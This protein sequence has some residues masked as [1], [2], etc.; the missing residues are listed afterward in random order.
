LQASLCGHLDVVQLLLDNGALC[1]RDTFQGERCLH[2]ALNDKIKKLL[3]DHDYSKSTNP[4]Q[5]YAAH[6]TS[7]LSRERPDTFDLQL[8]CGNA[9]LQAHK[10]ILA[11]RSPHFAS[12]LNQAPEMAT[13]K[14][15]N[16]VPVESIYAILRFMYLSEL[17]ND[18][19]TDEEEEDILR[20]IEKFSRHIDI[21]RLF[22]FAL[23]RSDRRLT[24]QR[25]TD[26][27][28]RGRDEIFAWF[29]DN[30]L[31][32]KLTV[33]SSKVADI[34]WNRHNSVFADVL[35]RA[36]DYDDDDN[37]SESNPSDLE[38]AS[39]PQTSSVPIGPFSNPSRP[40]SPTSTRKSVL[41]PVHKAILIRS[42]YFLTMFSSGFK[43]AQNSEYLQIISMDC[44]PDVLEVVLGFLYAEISDCPLEI[45]LEVL[46]AADMMLLEKLK[47]KAATTISSLANGVS[48]VE[49]ES[50]RGQTEADDM[51]EIYEILRSAWAL[52]VPKL[53]EFAARYIA[54]RLEHYIDKEEFAQIVKESAERVKNREETDTIELIDDIR[55][56]LSERFRL[57]FEDAGL[58]DM[59]NEEAI[60][61]E[62][63]NRIDIPVGNEDGI[64]TDETTMQLLVPGVVRTLDGE[65]VED[66]FDED[67]K[68]YQILLGKI[69]T[70]LE[71]LKLDA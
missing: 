57:R 44:P 24:R 43:E 53:E 15:P 46:Y 63:G 34:K 70:L 9:A 66:E 52:R 51:V 61:D 27:L 38:A 6:I 45:A 40:S 3:V 8:V 37:A 11:A 41:Y 12:K 59:M 10:F 67:A 56:Y 39:L 16:T 29:K 64:T 68:N 26:E 48:V 50:S 32:N 20:G 13:L 33:D 54:N 55:Y 19:G 47:T 17:P 18:L 22:D 65:D 30:V 69:E 60:V 36:D 21:E 31:K 25:M 1:E 35:L 5:P 14:L 4:L 49:A 23:N 62:N 71:S 28:T 58:E 7:L 2:N 42:E